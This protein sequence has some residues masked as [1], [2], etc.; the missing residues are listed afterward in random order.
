MNVSSNRRRSPPPGQLL[1]PKTLIFYR[2][3]VSDEDDDK[4]AWNRAILQGLVPQCY[5]SLLQHA[6]A[7]LQ[8]PSVHALLPVAAVP[9]YAAYIQV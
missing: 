9:P 4:G 2:R 1:N 6:A 8:H 5:V 7:L 3:S